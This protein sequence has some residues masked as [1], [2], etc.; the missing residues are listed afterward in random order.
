MTE[1]HLTPLKGTNPLGFFAALGT[2]DVLGRTNPGLHARLR[3]EGS[4]LPHAVIDGVAD[5]DQVIDAVDRDR[6]SWNDSV[7]FNGPDPTDPAADL[8]PALTEVRT[9]FDAAI[10]EADLRLLHS[11]LSEGAAA[12]VGG[13]KPTHLHFTAGQQK[14]L[15]MARELRDDLSRADIEEALCGPWTYTSE[16]K[17]FGWDNGR[18]E[19]IHALRG[20]AP[21]GDKKTGIPGADWLALL[22]LRFFPVTTRLGRLRTTRCTESWK[23]GSFDWP[24][25][26][27]PLSPETIGALLSMNLDS[28]SARQLRA[29]GVSNR[30]AAGIRRS[31]QGGY[32]SFGPASGQPE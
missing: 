22:G 19:R 20:F 18:G 26:D 31:D 24:L 14:F 1:L 25:W 16:K 10:D 4:L 3:W 15:V 6:R 2:L 23:S 32:G 8:K 9:W 27:T 21:S 30:Y 12:G 28:V 5:I 13:A 17:V 7:S 29:F 11:L